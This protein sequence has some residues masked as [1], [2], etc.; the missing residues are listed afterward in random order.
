MLK[1]LGR[2]RR[3]GGHRELPGSLRTVEDD[4]QHDVP[5]IKGVAYLCP[6]WQGDSAAVLLVLEL[7]EDTG[8]RPEIVSIEEL[9]TLCDLDCPP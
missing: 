6:L 8:T 2:S 5:S 4:N 1:C 7:A 9:L 3:G